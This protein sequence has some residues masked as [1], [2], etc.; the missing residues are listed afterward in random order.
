[1]LQIDFF[2]LTKVLQT[3]SKTMVE[4]NYRTVNGKM[5]I[6]KLMRS[7]PGNNNGSPHT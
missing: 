4:G 3:L 5:L 1:M 6:L 2:K 7:F